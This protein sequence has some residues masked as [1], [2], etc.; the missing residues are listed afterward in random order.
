ME[1]KV[2]SKE[3][4]EF[5]QE[6]GAYF[7]LTSAATNVGIMELFKEL[8]KR[9]L[10][11]NYRYSKEKEYKELIKNKERSKSIK[12]NQTIIHKNKRFFWC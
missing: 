6:I 11:P 12:L 10:D 3:G 5:A 1:E 2:S 9:Y 7:K 4:E 8:G